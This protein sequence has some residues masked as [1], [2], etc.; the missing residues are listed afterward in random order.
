MALKDLF[1]LNK[2]KQ[3]IV[4]NKLD[5]YLL[6]LNNEDNDRAVN[7]NSPSQIF[8]C[9]RSNYYTRKKEKKDTINVNARTRRIFDNGHSV[10]NR[11]QKYLKNAGILLLDEVPVVNEEYNVQGHTDGVLLIDDKSREL[12][13][14]EIKSCNSGTFKELIKPIEEHELQ[15]LLYMYCLEQR[16]VFLRKSHKNKLQ[17]IAKRKE[18]EIEIKKRYTHL[19]SG[20]RFTDDEKIKYQCELYHKMDNIL[21]E[22]SLPITKLVVLYENKDTQ[23]IKEFLIDTL[24][25]KK[26]EQYLKEK[27]DILNYCREMNYFVDN[28]IIPEREGDSKSCSFCRYC[29][30]KTIC[31]K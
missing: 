5:T 20:D 14:L 22:T 13:I 21:F 31:W 8:K 4:L 26:K 24:D 27:E 2:S 25:I 28:N 3:S 7:V 19:Q 10:H 17:F 9:K 30:Y 23:E 16:R 18:R 29:S 12:G 6:S 15:A 1:D 11:L